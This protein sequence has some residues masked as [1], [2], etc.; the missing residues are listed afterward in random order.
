M[1]KKPKPEPKPKKKINSRAK[2]ATA[3]LELAHFLTE[4]G[5]QSRRGQQFS[6]GGDSPDVVSTL[7]FHIECKRVQS[8]NL[9]KWMAQAKR[10]AK[11]KP[12]MVV[13][14]RNGEEWVAIIPL[15]NLLTFLLECPL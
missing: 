14:R 3:E 4:R 12:P 10:D 15:E 1:A 5:Y 11:G 2:G 7:P 13:H 6:G 9:Y 8:G